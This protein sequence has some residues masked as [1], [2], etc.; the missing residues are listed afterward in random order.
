MPQ[1][2]FN[3]HTFL[4]SDEQNN[5]IGKNILRIFIECLD[6][7][8]GSR[9][10]LTTE[11]LDA[12]NYYFYTANNYGEMAEE[13]AEKENNEGD[14]QV[15]TFQWELPSIEFEG[16]WENLIY[17]IDDCPK[18]KLTN[19]ISTSLKFARFGIDPK[20]LSRNHL[21]LLN[22]IFYLN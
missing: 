12:A 18:S 5:K 16:F 3:P 14:S 11:R 19:F 6:K 7:S 8:R 22:G 13:V 9:I 21:I 1:F 4:P 20:I 10:D 17:E 2:I 15:G